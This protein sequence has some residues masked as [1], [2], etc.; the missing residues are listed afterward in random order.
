MTYG[1]GRSG[2]PNLWL[3]VNA[4][5]DALPDTARTPRSWLRQ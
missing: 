2:K 3:T 5:N 4:D 1:G